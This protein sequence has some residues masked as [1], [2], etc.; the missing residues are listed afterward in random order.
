MEAFE[1]ECIATSIGE[2]R[3]FR[4]WRCLCVELRFSL[5]K[6]APCSRGC[7]FYCRSQIYSRR[8]QSASSD[9]RYYHQWLW[10]HEM[11]PENMKKQ[12]ALALRSIQWSYAIFWSSS[13][14]QPGGVSNC[15]S[16]SSPSKL[17]K[18]AHKPK[19]LQ[20]QSPEDLTD[21][22]WYYLVCMSFVFNIGQGLL[23][24]ALANGPPIWLNNAN[25][26]DCRVFSR[27]LLAK[28]SMIES[29][30]RANRM[31]VDYS[32]PQMES[33]LIIFGAQS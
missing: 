14:T 9:Q 13:A 30:L 33:L 29:Y 16:Y 11:V 8:I 2:K 21:T 23:G 18:P 27:S 17:Q 15:E 3:G 28:V 4:V 6:A 25:S 26:T 24:R 5:P 10:L 7:I 31:F 22:E 1:E 12:L 32:E 20:R 19:G